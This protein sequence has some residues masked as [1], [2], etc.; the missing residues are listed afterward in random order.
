MHA[1]NSILKFA[2]VTTVVELITNNDEKAYS[3]EVRALGE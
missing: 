2:D 3:E 1:S